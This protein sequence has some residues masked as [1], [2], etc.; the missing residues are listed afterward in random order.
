MESGFR[1]RFYGETILPEVVNTPASLSAQVAASLQNSS[2][3]GPALAVRNKPAI[4][5]VGSGNSAHALS[6]YFSSNGHPVHMLARNQAKLESLTARKAIV[7][8]GIIEGAFEIAQATN[9]A[10]SVLD[11]CDTIFVATV[12]NAYA[13]V[14]HWI[15]P[16]LTNK[17]TV[18]LFSGKVGGVLEFEKTLRECGA[19]NATVLETDNLFIGRL[20][21]DNSIWIRGCKQWTLFSASSRSQTLAKADA[22]LKF[23]PGLEAATNI[24][25]RG[26]TDYGAFAHGI[27]TLANMNAVDRQQP[28]LFYYEGFTEKTVALLDAL[29]QEFIAIAH[30]YETSLI[31]MAELLNRYYGCDTTNLLIAMQTV[32]NYRHSKGPTSLDHRFITEDVAC[33]LVPLSEFADLAG[34][35]TPMIDS[36]IALSSVLTKTNLRATGRTLATLGLAE[37]SYKQIVEGINA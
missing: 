20:Q 28:F 26:L 6:S 13:D 4:A 14:A 34:V 15:A 18:I 35:N 36:V 37:Q 5:V 24:V 17:H 19:A 33:S 11:A 31:P 7:A 8:T 10:K 29:E 16:Y 32:P 12:A 23:F 9:D 1:S 27:G 25:Q 3:S 21:P 2:L 22:L 30:A